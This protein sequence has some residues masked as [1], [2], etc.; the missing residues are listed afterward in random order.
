[1]ARALGNALAG[2]GWEVEWISSRAPGPARHPL[3]VAVADDALE[4]VAAALAERNS[5]G[6]ALH[7]SGLHGVEALG[8]LARKGFECGS[9]HPLQ[10]VAAGAPPD[11]FDGAGFAV[12]GS[13]PARDFAA[14]V[15]AA[16]GGFV[17]EIAPESRAVYHAAAAMASNYVTALADASIR[18]LRIAGLSGLAIRPACSGERR[19][20]AVLPDSCSARARPWKNSLE[21]SCAARIGRL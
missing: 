6:I 16:L 11:V 9:L 19:P 20:A 3:I 14:R 12:A 21:A 13:S 15:A 8:A 1:M 2:R 18:L 10:T 7:T 17:F 5:G 4:S